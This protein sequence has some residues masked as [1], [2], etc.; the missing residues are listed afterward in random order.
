MSEDLHTHPKTDELCVFWIPADQTQPMEFKTLK[1][2]WYS[3]GEF[4]GGY[5]E[6]VST[7]L[8]PEL[9]CGCRMVMAVNENGHLQHL[10]LNARASLFYPYSPGIVGDA[11]M[12]GEGLVGAKGMA[13]GTPGEEVAIDFFSLPQ[14]IAGWKGPGFD[15]PNNKQPWEA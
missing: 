3:L 14:A 2:N 6:R 10:P 13:I 5:L 7:D 8:M 12:V 9:H 15:L 11:F 1:N 4:L